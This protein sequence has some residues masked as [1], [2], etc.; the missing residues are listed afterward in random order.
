MRRIATGRERSLRGDKAWQCNSGGQ[1]GSA[2]GHPPPV[3]GA[4]HG[5]TRDGADT[6]VNS[7]AARPLRHADRLLF[8]AQVWPPESRDIKGLAC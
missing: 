2:G 7:G 6:G 8:C 1:T 4:I 5:N 3:V